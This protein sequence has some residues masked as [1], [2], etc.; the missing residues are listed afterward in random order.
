MS[1]SQLNRNIF[2]A[3]GTTQKLDTMNPQQN[4]LLAQLLSLIQGQGAQG[5]GQGMDYFQDLLGGGEGGFQKFAAPYMRDF[6]EQ[7]VPQLAERLTAQGGGGGRSSAAAQ[8][9]GQAGAGL[10]EKLAALRS[11]LQ[12][13]AAQ[14]LLNTFFQGTSQ[15]LGARP[16]GYQYQPGDPGMLGYFAQAFGQALPGMLFGGF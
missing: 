16:F 7:T 11:S 15:G 14:Q 5:F 2:G 6:Q 1:I 4:Q 9:F 13:G 12:G 10:Q 8:A 3:P